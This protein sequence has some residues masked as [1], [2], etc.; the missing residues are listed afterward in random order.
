ME[1]VIVQIDL[2]PFIWRQNLLKLQMMVRI[3]QATILP[4]SATN[5]PFFIKNPS[6]ECNLWRDLL[7]SPCGRGFVVLFRRLDVGYVHLHPI[8]EIVEEGR[9]DLAAIG[10]DGM[11]LHEGELRAD[12]VGYLTEDADLDIRR[13]G[14]HRLVEVGEDAVDAGLVG[15]D[16]VGIQ[17]VDDAGTLGIG[18]SGVVGRARVGTRRTCTHSTSIRP[19]GRYREDEEGESDEGGEAHDRGRLYLSLHRIQKCHKVN[20]RP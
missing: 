8:V 11:S 20:R 16:E 9:E 5:S 15:R 4:P 14:L 3:I 7:L 18:R 2:L 13:E 12:G 6:T 10:T 1:M 17:L 19:H